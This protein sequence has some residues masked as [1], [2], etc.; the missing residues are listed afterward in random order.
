MIA[1]L[2]IQHQASLLANM[3]VAKDVAKLKII[4][5]AVARIINVYLMD[6]VLSVPL[7]ETAY[8]L[9]EVRVAIMM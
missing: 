3:V 8:L 2:A 9:H 5:N 7:T 1:K 6:R 4:V